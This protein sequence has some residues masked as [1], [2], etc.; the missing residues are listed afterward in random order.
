[1]KTDR[2]FFFVFLF[3]PFVFKLFYHCV[4]H[5]VLLGLFIYMKTIL[6]QSLRIVL[7]KVKRFNIN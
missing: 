6:K 2:V 3:L 1:M 5:R 7:T 4:R